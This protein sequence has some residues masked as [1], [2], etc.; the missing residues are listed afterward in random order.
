DRPRHGAGTGPHR[1]AGQQGRAARRSTAAGG[2]FR[3]ERSRRFDVP[4]TGA[5]H[6]IQPMSAGTSG[7]DMQTRRGRAM[8]RQWHKLLGGVGAI[9]MLLAVQ[10]AHAAADDPIV[11]GMVEPYTGE[12]ANY[13][14]WVDDAWKLAM[15]VYGDK[16][17]GHPIKLVR[18]DSKC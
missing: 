4:I 13:G 18:A 7:R 2:I 5:R 8:T 9:G 14:Q 10:P 12:E 11:I 17:K 6:L 15:E 3:D 16:I 1:A